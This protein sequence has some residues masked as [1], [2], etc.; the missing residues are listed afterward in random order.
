MVP[1][2]KNARVQLKSIEILQNLNS[3]NYSLTIWH[4]LTK[5]KIKMRKN[6][7][8]KMGKRKMKSEFKRK[9]VETNSTISRRGGTF[10]ATC[11]AKL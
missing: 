11:H 4:E 5:G 3:Q 9:D 6:D 7:S 2:K 10:R 1:L 8:D